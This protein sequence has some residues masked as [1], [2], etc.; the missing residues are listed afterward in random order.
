MNFQMFI[1]DL[2]KAEETEIKLSTSVGSSKKQ[3]NSRKTSTSASL[4]MLKLLC[5]DCNNLLKIL[6]DMGIPYHLTCLLR[7]L[8]SGQEATVRTIHGTTDWFQ[9]GKGVLQSCI[10]NLIY[11]TYIQSTSC[12]MPHWMGEIS[13]TSD[14]HWHHPYDRK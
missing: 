2:E 7:N 8:Y 6:N 11:L 13:I 1:L 14:M 9:V 12:K 3:E 5:V 10:C 4:T